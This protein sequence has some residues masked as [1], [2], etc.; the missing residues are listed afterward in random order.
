MRIE[1]WVY[2]LPLRLRSL[3]RRGS[4]ERELDEELQYHLERKVEEFLGAGADGGGSAAGGAA[5]DG[6]AYP[7][8]RGVPRHATRERDRRPGSGS[9]VRRSRAREVAGVYGGG[10]DDAGAGDRGEC[11][12]VRGAERVDPAAVECAAGGE[13]V[14]APTRQGPGVVAI[15]SGLSRPAG[16]Q[17]HL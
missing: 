7:T 10:G 11:G 2:A 9:A 6:R 5:G 15:V 14:Y 3:F 8:Q 1:H 13:P 16:P 4:V 17:P 12:G